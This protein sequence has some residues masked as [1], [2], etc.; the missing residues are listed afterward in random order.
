VRCN[1]GNVVRAGGHLSVAVD[2]GAEKSPRAALT[3]N[4]QHAQDLQEPHPATQT[5]HTRVGLTSVESDVGVSQLNIPHEIKI[6][7]YK[8][9]N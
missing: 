9:K 1:A 3:I 2:D 7:K 4:V 6:F 8:P 5:T